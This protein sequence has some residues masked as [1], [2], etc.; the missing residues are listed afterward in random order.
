M[1]VVPSVDILD[2]ECVQ[3]VGGKPGTGK[4][5]GS[6]IVA[7]QRWVKEGASYLHII[8]LNAAMGAGDNLDLIRKLLSEVNVKAQVGGGIRSL[9]KAMNLLRWGADKVIFGTAA[10]QCPTIVKEAIELVGGERV[11]VALDVRGGKLSIEGWRT[12]VEYSIIE[13]AK[14]FEDMGVG[15]LLFTN[16]DVEGKMK[17]IPTDMIRTILR[18]V[19]IPLFVAGGVAS[20]EDV[21][22]VRD[23]GAAGLVIGRALYEGKIKLKQATEVAK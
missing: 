5:Y 22:A 4:S 3:L 23:A 20:L 9:E 6:P 16:V 1:L 2:G 15:S 7:A 11:M 21:R 14:K 8:D 10:I 19:K 17:G 12:Q 18:S 13:L